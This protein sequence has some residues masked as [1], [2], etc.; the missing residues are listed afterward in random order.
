VRKV[1]KVEVCAPGFLE[2]VERWGIVSAAGEAEAERLRLSLEGVVLENLYGRPGIAD[3]ATIYLCLE[4]SDGRSYHKYG[5]SRPEVLAPLD[6]FL[7]E[8]ANTVGSCG[9]SPYVQSQC[10]P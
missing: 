3:D 6:S 8:L 7:H 10:S 2:C 5:M 4:R 9:N 1:V